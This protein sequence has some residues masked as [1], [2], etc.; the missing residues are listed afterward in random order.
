MY[1][2]KD[3]YQELIVDHNRSPRNFGEM[4]DAE[5]VA[6]GYNPLCGDRLKLFLKFSDGVVSDVRFTGDGC[7]ISIASTSLMTEQLRGKNEEEIHALFKDFQAMVTAD[8]DTD[9]IAH[10]MPNKLIAFA[11]V[12][13]YPAR[14]KCATLCWHTLESA[15]ADTD[16]TTKTE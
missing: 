16:E 2:L 5:R 10:D 1:D 7:A 4:A 3:L 13:Q 8:M 12:K 15:L 9:N 14:V 6:E 11:G